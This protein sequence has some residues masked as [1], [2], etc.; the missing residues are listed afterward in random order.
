MANGFAA[1]IKGLIF[2]VIFLIIWQIAKI[3]IGIWG[4][5]IFFAIILLT[6]LLSV[7]SISS[8]LPTAKSALGPIVWTIV[9]LAICIGL[10]AIFYTTGD[11]DFKS[12]GPKKGYSYTGNYTIENEA[13][14]FSETLLISNKAD[15][16]YNGYGLYVLQGKGTVKITVENYEFPEISFSEN[17]K[18][19]VGL[20]TLGTSY[21]RKPQVWVNDRRTDYPATIIN[22][23]NPHYVKMSVSC[24]SDKCVIDDIFLGN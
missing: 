9:I 24:A 4:I 6:I 2:G 5:V 20:K 22:L 19:K 8:K 3:N 1:I 17:T 23:D 18:I 13:L 16:T 11:E 14:E 12:G 21:S 10:I 7:F 15:R